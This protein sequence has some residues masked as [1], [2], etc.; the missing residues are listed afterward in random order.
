MQG[1]DKKIRRFLKKYETIFPAVNRADY[2]SL[3]T[4]GKTFTRQ[5][6]TN[7]GKNQCPN[8]GMSKHCV[9]PS[10]TAKIIFPPNAKIQF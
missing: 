8:V 7:N 10:K 9:Y 3:S 1:P 6:E 4:A 2:P 5:K